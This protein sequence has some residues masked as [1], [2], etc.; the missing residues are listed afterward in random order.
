MV[1]GLLSLAGRVE[2]RGGP[3]LRPPRRIGAITQTRVYWVGGVIAAVF[4]VAR[5]LL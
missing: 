5:N 4:T 3:A 1:L 2:V